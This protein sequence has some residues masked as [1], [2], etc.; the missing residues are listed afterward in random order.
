MRVEKK[1]EYLEKVCKKY[2]LKR[3]SLIKDIVV[4]FNTNEEYLPDFTV[5]FKADKKQFLDRYSD[6]KDRETKKT[7]NIIKSDKKPFDIELISDFPPFDDI[8]I[9]TYKLADS[10]G[11][12]GEFLFIKVFMV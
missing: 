4:N 3:H 11:I 7:I 8:E 6:I 5:I 10:I 2:F 1:I 12:E 9:Q